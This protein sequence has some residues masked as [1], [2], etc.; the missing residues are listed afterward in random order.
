MSEQLY[1]LSYVSTANDGLKLSD[2][3]NILNAAKEYN[4]L[5]DITGILIYCN[6]TFFQILEGSKEHIEEVFERIKIDSRHDNIIKIQEEQIQERKFKDWSMAFK[7]F[8]KELSA[9]DYFN[10][11]QFYSHTKDFSTSNYNQTSLKVLNDFF[12]LNG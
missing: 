3:E 12:D 9:L 7:S 11:E 1:H 6:K 8:N 10:N 4:S 2:F 5:L